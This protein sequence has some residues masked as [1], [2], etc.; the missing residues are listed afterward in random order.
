[1]LYP[2][3]YPT[4]QLQSV[5]NSSQVVKADGSSQSVTLQ[6]T[7]RVLPSPVSYRLERGPGGSKLGVIKLTS[8]N[9]RAQRD[10]AAALA[11]LQVRVLY[12]V[13]IIFELVSS[14]PV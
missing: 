5:L 1:M 4:A 10:V 2:V 11:A 6:R 7:S 3:V 9:A 13:C 14:S 8:F 12:S